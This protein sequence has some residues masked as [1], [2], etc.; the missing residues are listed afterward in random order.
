LSACRTE[1]TGAVLATPTVRHL[2]RHILAGNHSGNSRNNDSSGK[3]SSSSSSSSS[4][5]VPSRMLRGQEVQQLSGGSQTKI[6]HHAPTSATAAPPDAG[7]LRSQAVPHIVVPCPEPTASPA[8]SASI[9]PV[10]AS[11]SSLP[12]AAVDERILSSPSSSSKSLEPPTPKSSPFFRPRILVVEDSFPNRKLLVMLLSALKCDVMGVENGL[13]AVQQFAPW[14][15]ERWVGDNVAGRKE[16]FGSSS[17]SLR[18]GSAPTAASSSSSRLSVPPVPGSAA[19]ATASSSFSQQSTPSPS[20][21]AASAQLRAMG[22]SPSGASLPSGGSVTLA[23][24][25][26]AAASASPATSIDAAAAA[27]RGSSREPQHNFDLI[28]IVCVARACRTCAPC[29]SG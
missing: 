15:N 11:T 25:H 3:S 21:E 23:Y 28:F 5:D 17:A 6:S 12:E 16:S 24:P 9:A 1:T 8:A 14:A 20:D 13:L 10:A 19:A 27:P 26:T 2:S 29:A 22:V 7:P 4:G 18:A